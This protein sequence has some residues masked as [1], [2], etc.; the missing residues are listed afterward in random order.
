LLSAIW[1]VLQ[2]YLTE[3][4]KHT[5]DISTKKNDWKRSAIGKFMLLYNSLV[6][7]EHSSVLLHGELADIALRNGAVARTVIRSRLELLSTSS[8]AF[9]ESARE[10]NTLLSI[11]NDELRIVIK[12][13]RHNK[14]L[15]WRNLDLWLETLPNNLDNQGHMSPTISFS[16]DIPTRG[17][18]ISLGV[19]LDFPSHRE[20]ELAEDAEQIRKSVLQKLERGYLDLSDRPAVANQLNSLNQVIEEMQSARSELAA[21]IR[22]HFPLDKILDQ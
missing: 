1:V 16:K 17:S 8:K 13:F 22:M 19:L 3:L 14:Y 7:L 2:P 12:G 21:F 10:V 20:A 9:V 4:F 15:A 5:L 11:Y 18:V 6:E